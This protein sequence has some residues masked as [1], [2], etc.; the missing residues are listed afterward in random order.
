MIR[1]FFFF[2]VLSS[3]L[4]RAQE[5]LIHKVEITAEAVVIHYNLID[6]TSERRYTVNVYS[7]KDNFLA[8]LQ[9]VSGDAGLEVAPGLNRK[10]TWASKE[11][12]GSSFNGDVEIEIRGRVYVPFI[13]FND[14]QENMAIKRGKAKTLTWTGGTRQNILNFAIYKGDNYVDVIPNIANAGSYDVVLPTSIKPGKSYYFLVSD[15][16][17]K[18][19]VMKTKNFTVKRKVPLL[20]KVLPVAALVAI[21]PALS[22]GSSGSQDLETPPGPP[23]NP[24]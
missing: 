1:Y 19:Q 13:R 11:E 9:K 10:I 21:V 14:F 20:A 22:G 12:L 4:A 8:P 23:A 7:S 15:S 5:F 18:D 17:N 16:K 6:T 3:Q 24:N 2:G